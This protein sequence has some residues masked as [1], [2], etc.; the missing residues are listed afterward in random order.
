MKEIKLLLKLALCLMVVVGVQSNANGAVAI[1]TV[2]TN[3]SGQN[4]SFSGNCNGT[5]TLQT[6]NAFIRS[7]AGFGYNDNVSIT[8]SPMVGDCA[9]YQ[10]NLEGVWHLPLIDPNGLTSSFEV[11][12]NLTGAILL[13]GVFR[14][15]ILHGR[16]GSSSLA[17]T[18]PVDNVTYTPLS[19]WFP[20]NFPRNKGTFAIAIVSQTRVRAVPFDGEA[21][22]PFAFNANG[23]INFGR[24]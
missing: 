9:T 12:D 2:G 15:A 22:G 1:A 20:V 8:F 10:I 24:Q 6:F 7:K 23:D 21:G 16:S 5:F 13:R 14:G 19:L 17:V 11:T 3:T 4:I 18:L